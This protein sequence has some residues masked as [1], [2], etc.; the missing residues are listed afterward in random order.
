MKSSSVRA[1]HNRHTGKRCCH[2]LVLLVC[3]GMTSGVK[4]TGLLMMHINEKQKQ[5][6]LNGEIITRADLK[7]NPSLNSHPG[8]GDLQLPDSG[9]ETDDFSGYEMLAIEMA[10]MPWAGN[11]SDWL[12]VYNRLTAYGRLAGTAYYSTTDDRVQPFIVSSGR[13]DSPHNERLLADVRYDDLP[14]RQVN[15]F[16]IEDNRFGSLLF[17]SRVYNDGTDLVM[18]NQSLRPMRKLLMTINR[19]GEYRLNFYFSYDASAGGIFYTAVHAMRIRSD[20]LLGL[21]Q[22]TTTSF[23]NRI[24]A[25]TVRMAERLGLDWHD[26]LRAF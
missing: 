24:R 18:L 16:R 11:A 17:E 3:L 6:M 26:R 9:Y 12:A 23:A 15:Y 21:P 5:L 13:I 8:I 7:N 10:F 22:L 19:A 14:A 2:W 4:A 25:T 20:L 1:G